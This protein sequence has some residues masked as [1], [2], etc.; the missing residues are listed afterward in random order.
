MTSAA[1]TSIPAPRPTPRE[2]PI[3]ACSSLK[4]SEWFTPPLEDMTPTEPALRSDTPGT[5]LAVSPRLGMKK[6]EVLGPRSLI[7]VSL[8]TSTTSC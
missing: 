8:M 2:T 6:P 4:E 7:P 5:K 3:P 1:V